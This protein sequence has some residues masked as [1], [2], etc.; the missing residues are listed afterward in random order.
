MWSWSYQYNLEFNVD[1]A[2]L[3]S[4]IR[5]LHRMQNLASMP[6]GCATFDLHLV[7]IGILPTL[8]MKTY[9]SEHV[10][11]SSLSC[12]PM[13]KCCVF[14]RGKPVRLDI[15]GMES[16][17]SGTSRCDAQ[18]AATSFQLHLQVPLARYRKR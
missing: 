10:E 6:T 2:P 3:V 15:D 18:A 1:P 17:V 16:V 11:L 14:R 13:N 9:R 8:K 5:R 12:A 4:G 7:T